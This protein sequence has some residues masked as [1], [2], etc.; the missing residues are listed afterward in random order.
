MDSY[1][2]SFR[3][4]FAIWFATLVVSFSI[5]GCTSLRN[6][7]EDSESLKQACVASTCSQQAN[8][9]CPVESKEKWSLRDC[10]LYAFQN[11]EG[12]RGLNARSQAQDGAIIEA[13]S[14][15]LP[16]ATVGYVRGN[17]PETGDID[18]FNMSLRTLVW[19]SGKTKSRVRQIEAEQAILS[20]AARAEMMK[21]RYEIKSAYYELLHSQYLVQA[22]QA[23][24]DS[25]K[26]SEGG[27]RESDRLS[28][29]V[30][31]AR[32]EQALFKA[33]NA[34]VSAQQR[35]NNL[36]GRPLRAPLVPEG[37]LE[38]RQIPL[39]R[40]KL[41]E[42]A[43]AGNPVLKQLEKGIDKA[44]YAKEEAR[45]NNYPDFHASAFLEYR[46]T[47]REVHLVGR[48]DEL[49]QGRAYGVGVEVTL[50]LFQGFGIAYGKG[51]QAEEMIANSQRSYE[52]ARRR[53]AYEVEEIC[54]RME[55]AVRGIHAS[56][57][58]VQYHQSVLGGGRNETVSQTREFANNQVELLGY[59]RDY[60]IAKADLER[61]LAL[62][63]EDATLAE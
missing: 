50:P 18:Y 14:A 36:M 37:N 54:N 40:E 39:H 45:R 57:I 4:H 46:D 43:L 52:A 47:D 53:L 38:F 9:A 44:Y 21:V 8:P 60:N 26:L 28:S 63:E 62:P 32:A 41:V 42:K 58:A 61:L 31:V 33:N 3:Y 51:K 24:L 48:D 7:P 22:H 12:I 16:T 2:G 6:R 56:Q 20:E 13:W 49:Y 11:N 23:Q 10:V 15:Y 59:I 30:N 27:A 29:R 34:Y 1:R 5:I 17:T 25:A 55:E 35:L 19:D